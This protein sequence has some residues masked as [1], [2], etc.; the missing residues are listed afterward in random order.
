MRVPGPTDRSRSCWCPRVSSRCRWPR[1]CTATARPMGVRV[2]PVY[3]GQPIGRQLYAMRAGV[4]VVIATPGRALDHLRR[5]SLVMRSRACSGARRGRRDARHGFRRGHRG[6]PQGGARRTPD[7]AVL[8][9]D[10]AAHRG[11]RQAQPARSGAHPHRQGGG[12]GRR[13]AEGAPAGI[14]PARAAPRWRRSAASSTTS[15]PRPRSSSAAPAPRSTSSPRS[16][17]RRV[18]RPTALHGGMTQEQ[19]DQ[20]MKRLRAGNSSCS[21]P[22]MSPRAGSTSSAS[23]T[24]STTTCRTPPR[25]TCTAS[26]ASGAPGAKVS[27]SRWSSRASTTCCATSSASPSRR[28]RSP[29]CPRLR[30]CARAASS[31]RAHRCA[32]RWSPTTSSISALSSTP[33]HTSSTR[34]R[35]RWRR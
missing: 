14:S 30:T 22:P 21:S 6:G 15:R 33:S 4:D 17:T 16:S 13:G 20:V 25:P 5:G 2:L 34:C 35:S 18:T 3:G 7:G 8:G 9:H 19:R 28:S 29:R 31:S 10:A 23:P 11:D 1:P 27:R 32:R 24:S 12:E 26:A